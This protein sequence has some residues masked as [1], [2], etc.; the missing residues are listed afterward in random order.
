MEKDD[1][2]WLDSIPKLSDERIILNIQGITLALERVKKDTVIAMLA[3]KLGCLEV[4]AR[5]RNLLV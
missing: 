1:F 2:K 5:K 3:E 4:E